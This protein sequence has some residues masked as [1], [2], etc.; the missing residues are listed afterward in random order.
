M[1]YAILSKGD[2]AMNVMYSCDNNYLR[3]AAASI[4]SLLENNKT[5]NI[6]IFL[7]TNN[8]EE[9]L[10]QKIKKL[11][12][13]YKQNI[14]FIDINLICSKLKTNDNFPISGYARLFVS[15]YITVDK[16]LYLDCDTIV[17]DSIKSL[18]DTDISNYY[19]AGI[20]DNPAKHLV[21]IIGMTENDRYLNSGVLLI[22]LQK[23]REDNLE[24]QFNEF[25]ERFNGKVPHHDQGIINGV[26]K[27]KILV[28]NPKYNCMSQ[29]FQ[30]TASEI[31]RLFNIKNY[32]T[33]SELDDALKNP[34]IVHYI[35]K[36]F[37]RPWIK[38]CT[39]PYLNEYIKYLKLSGF[40]QEPI[41]KKED[42][43]LK[44][45]KFIYQKT[46]FLIYYNFEKLLD[47]KRRYKFNKEYK[48]INK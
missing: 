28:L 20:Q 1:K 27:N 18:Y 30:H 38:E 24:I 19:V 6:N 42:I 21:D 34:V 45:R 11:V 9:S 44:I 37:G 7:I 47:I 40:Y 46:P 5:E 12:N 16:I 17:L 23:W 10:Q 4:T 26:C 25:I 43:G 41:E 13:K 35:A 48:S 36:F 32:Y 31:K 22:N 29:L 39:H 14:E 15:Q 8:I 33:Q 2:N 3:H